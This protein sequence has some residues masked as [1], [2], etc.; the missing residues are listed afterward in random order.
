MVIPW[1]NAYQAGGYSW[2]NT[3]ELKFERLKMIFLLIMFPT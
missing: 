2:V 1:K 3:Y